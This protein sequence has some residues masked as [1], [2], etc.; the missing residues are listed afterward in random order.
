LARAAELYGLAVEEVNVERDPALEAQ[1]GGRLPVLV[2]RGE[3]VVAGKVS[4][5]AL[6]AALRRV[7]GGEN[8]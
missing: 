5:E 3:E 2:V 8:A 7:L 1:F 6:F 4:E